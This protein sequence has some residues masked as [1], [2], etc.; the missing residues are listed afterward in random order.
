MIT[1]LKVN[2]FKSLNDFQIRF[3]KGLNVIVGPNGSGKTNICQA[4]TILSSLPTGDLLKC[5]NYLG[6]ASAIFS[7]Q[8][9]SKKISI[10]AIG[11]C[12]SNYKKVEYNLRYNYEFQIEIIDDAFHLSETLIIQRK[13]TK[14]F[15]QVLKITSKDG[16]INGI[17]VDRENLGDYAK[18][19]DNHKT[20]HFTLD[21]NDSLWGIMP[22]LFYACYTVGGDIINLRLVNID[23]NVVR[24]PCDI[25]DTDRMHG[26][27]KYL[28]NE[29]FKLLQ[30]NR[31]KYELDSLLEQTLPN[32]KSIKVEAN[33]SDL[34][35]HIWITS[36]NNC[37]FPSANLSDGTLKLIAVLV[38]IINQDYNI[39]IEELENY[40][41]P[42]VDRVLIDF[43]RESFNNRLCILTSH[44]ETILN[45]VQPSELIL[46]QNIEGNTICN[47]II[48]LKQIQDAIQASGLGCGYHYVLGNLE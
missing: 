25:I 2:G 22:K 20:I 1:E 46:C 27:G 16:E 4:L 34:K 23:P 17:I 10:T 48:N 9:D 8:H 6:G 15:K 26:N 37:S 18:I 44:S 24:E 5:L 29:L 21:N 39:I 45:L 19:L 7:K 32:Y 41:H 3:D 47:R 33:T 42:K 40:L 36:K 43:L 28:A 31:S 11:E 38:A 13:T 14:L 12:A 35:R 30:N